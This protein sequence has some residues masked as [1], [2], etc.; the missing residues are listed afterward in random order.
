MHILSTMS[1]ENQE[2][3]KLASWLMVVG[4]VDSIGGNKYFVTFIDAF[5]RKLW[6]YMIKKKSEVIEVFAKFKSMVE[7]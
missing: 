7:T 3:W 4:Q 5:S 1:Q 2:N 6:P